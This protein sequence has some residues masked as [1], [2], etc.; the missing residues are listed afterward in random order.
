MRPN[1][2]LNCVGIIK[3]LKETQNRKLL[4][5]TNALF[6][7]LLQ[8]VCFDVGTKLIHVSTD[9]VFSGKKGNYCDDDV[10]DAE[11]LYGRTKFLGEVGESP[12]LTLRTSIIGHGLASKSSLVDWFL[13]QDHKAV[14][15]YLHAIYTG[16]PTVVFCKELIRVIETYPELTGVYNVA[17][18]KIAK[19]DLLVLIRDTYEL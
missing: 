16:L 10:S 15:G 14:K 5:Y 12:A 18:Q 17:S 4:I 1:V 6:P 3:Q 7:H 2:V 11:D 9:C 19:Y 13:S 8:E